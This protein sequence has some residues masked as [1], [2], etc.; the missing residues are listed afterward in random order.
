M[1]GR[2]DA[3][4]LL[5]E[6]VRDRK[7][8]LHMIAV[9]A[10]MKELAK[11]FG[12]DEEVWELVGLLHDIDYERTKDDPS[13]HGLVAE[14]ILR[15]LVSEDI[16]RA[17]KAHNFENTGI[18]PRTRMEKALIASDAISG[19]IIACALVMPSKKLEEVKVR[20]IKRKFKQKDFARSV[21]RERILFCEQI[22]IPREKFFELALNALKGVSGELGL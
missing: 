18:E 16:L 22:G 8:I 9:G 20:T 3:L 19:L 13:R 5:E 15:S 17:I 14:E 12:E 4:R 11:Y 21:R 7:I 1:L 6:N 2:D 10:I